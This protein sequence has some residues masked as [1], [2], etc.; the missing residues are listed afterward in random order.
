[1]KEIRKLLEGLSDGLKMMAEGINAIAE[2]VNA[3]A[4]VEV[5]GKATPKESPKPKAKKAATKPKV[6]KKAANAKTVKKATAKKKEKKPAK[7]AAS[8]KDK[9]ETALEA[10]MEVLQ[11]TD[12]GLNNAALMEKTGFDSKKVS[13]I[14]FKL[15]KQ[16]R[17]KNVSRGVYSASI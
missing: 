13:N 4:V 14:L 3:I 15:K 9:S 17:I 8:A 2:K 1:M 6:V 7:A 10:V 16:G 5:E 12:Q 11:K